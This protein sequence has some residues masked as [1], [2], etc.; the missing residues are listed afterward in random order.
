VSQRLLQEDLAVSR[1]MQLRFSVTVPNPS[2]EPL[3]GYLV[4]RGFLLIL[5]REAQGIRRYLEA[6][7]SAV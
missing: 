4:A 2:F 6:K 5:F 7:G 3:R 1:L